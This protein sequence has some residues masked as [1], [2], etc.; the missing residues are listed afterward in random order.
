MSQ[1]YM[2]EK[3]KITPELEK[4]L[5]SEELEMTLIHRIMDENG[6]DFPAGNDDTGEYDMAVVEVKW[7][8]NQLIDLAK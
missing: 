4:Q 3:L 5:H 6:W 8:I 1:N 7:Y 2:T